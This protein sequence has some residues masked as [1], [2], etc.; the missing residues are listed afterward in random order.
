MLVEFNGKTRKSGGS[1]EYKNGLHTRVYKPFLEYF[2]TVDIASIAEASEE[3]MS[4]KKTCGE[5]F[6]VIV[7]K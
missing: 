3:S 5:W 6:C 1:F 2:R 7:G 4:S